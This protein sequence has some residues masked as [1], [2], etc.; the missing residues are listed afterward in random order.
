M[1]TSTAP[2]A[3]VVFTDTVITFEKPEP[4]ACQPTARGTNDYFSAPISSS[5]GLRCCVARLV[6][7]ARGVAATTT[8][9]PP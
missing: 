2:A 8:D 6:L 3:D 4:E 5:D 7:R 1:P 9:P